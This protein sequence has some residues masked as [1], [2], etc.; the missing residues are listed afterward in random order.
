MLRLRASSLSWWEARQLAL[1]LRDRRS[2]R[3]R[4]RDSR[5]FVWQWVVR[6]SGAFD[7]WSDEDWLWWVTTTRWDEK[8]AGG[9]VW[10][11]IR[12][13]KLLVAELAPIERLRL[14]LDGKIRVRGGVTRLIYEIEP[15]LWG[16]DCSERGLKQCTRHSR[17]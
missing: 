11:H 14:F 4:W 10:A 6:S 17:P 9:P 13:L 12:S 2:L 1:P 3:R 7:L 15:G 8:Y 5:V 16:C